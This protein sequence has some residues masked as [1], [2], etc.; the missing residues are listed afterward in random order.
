[1]PKLQQFVE[2]WSPISDKMPI[3]IRLHPWF[4]LLGSQRLEQL[5]KSIQLKIS[6]LLQHWEP[7]DKSALILL[8]PWLRVF[9]QSSWENLIIRCILP[10][11]LFALKDFEINPKKQKIEPLKWLLEW[12]DYIPRDNLVSILENNVLR[13]IVE[14]GMEWVSTPNCKI[15]EVRGWL[16]GWKEL[17]GEKVMNIPAVKHYFKSFENIINK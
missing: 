11:L 2:E 7:Q 1:M 16:S 12:A 14:V 9:E 13:K 8:K 6:Q 3:H 10:K 4:P 15:E 17:L 5:W